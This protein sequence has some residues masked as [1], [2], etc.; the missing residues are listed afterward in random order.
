MSY[1]YTLFFTIFAVIL[2][3]ICT[4]ESVAT[5]FILVSKLI[6]SRYERTKWWVLHNPANP[7]VKWIIWNR[8]MKMAKELQKELN[9]RK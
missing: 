8:S 1:Q 3:F 7:V 5:A 9:N 6:K 2:Y 4:D